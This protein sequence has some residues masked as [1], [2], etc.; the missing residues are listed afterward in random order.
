MDVAKSFDIASLPRTTKHASDF[1]APWPTTGDTHTVFG[2]TDD[3]NSLQEGS[4]IEA[5]SPLNSAN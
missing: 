4:V 5:R 1:A 3:G 2:K